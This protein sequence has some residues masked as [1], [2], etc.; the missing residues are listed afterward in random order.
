M[1]SRDI[2]ETHNRHLRNP[3]VA[4]EYINYAF[5]S[6][7]KAIIL[8]AIR[9]VVDAQEGG[10]SSIAERSHLGRESMYK[11]LSPNGNPKLSTL[12]ALFHSLGLKLSVQPD[13]T[14]HF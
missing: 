10:I 7:D 6:E 13:S 4:A 11:M 3:V 14:Q 2:R 8:M 9:N 1:S 5:A 12:N